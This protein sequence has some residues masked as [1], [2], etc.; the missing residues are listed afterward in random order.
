MLAAVE[1]GD[2]GEL[3]ELMRQDPGF[4][5][6]MDQD[7][8]GYTLLHYACLGD[9]RSAVIPLLLIHPDIDVNMDYYGDTPFMSRVCF[10]CS[11]SP[12]PRHPTHTQPTRKSLSHLVAKRGWK[13]AREGG[14]G[15]SSSWSPPW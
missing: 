2:A 13:A 6:N 1:K 5:V 12:S 10:V 7:G 14:G 11:L 4:D 8:Y 3:A 15:R 9:S